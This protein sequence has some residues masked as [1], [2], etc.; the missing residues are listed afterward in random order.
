MH[1]YI[2]VVKLL[3]EFKLLYDIEFFLKKM[4]QD[5]FYC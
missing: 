3:L 1:K 2:E 4:E 5:Y